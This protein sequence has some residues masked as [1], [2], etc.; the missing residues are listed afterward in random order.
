[1]PRAAGYAQRFRHL[2][3]VTLLRGVLD[4][5]IDAPPED[6][7]LVSPTASLLSREDLHPALVPL[8]IDAARRLH[9]E[10]GL[11]EKEGEFPS[12]ENLDAPVSVAARQYYASGPSFL[13]RWLPFRSAA[14]LDRLKIMLLPLLTLLV[15]LM[16]FAPPVY[17]WRIRYRIFRWY[18]L[19]LALEYGEQDP[20]TAGERL[21]TVR[22]MEEDIRHVKV[23]ASYGEELSNLRMHLDLVKGRLEAEQA[24]HA[25]SAANAG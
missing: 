4:F 13:Y 2:Q 20:A 14:T 25:A 24:A 8:F 19:L 5:E 11:F 23:P 10:G 7:P 22:A 17:R 12:P 6:I 15:P 1:M 21:E 16:R 3:P 18:K 9:E